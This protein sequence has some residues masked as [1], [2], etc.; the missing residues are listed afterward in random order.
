[1][2]YLDRYAR[3]WLE[4]R[5]RLESAERTIVVANLGSQAATGN[6]LALD[7]LARDVIEPIKRAMGASRYELHLYGGGRL[8]PEIS[9]ALDRPEVKNIGYIADIDSALLGAQVF[10]CLN[11][12][13]RYKVN[14]SRYLHAWSLGGCIV[15]HRDAALSLPEMV[16]G[17]NALLGESADEIAALVAQAAAH[18]PL[19]RRLGRNGYETYRRHFTA[20]SVAEDILGRMRAALGSD[21]RNVVLQS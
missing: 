10:L 17:E 13:T 6:M 5:E 16:H 18:K 12:A 3:A 15:A 21:D 2:I 7:Y 9:A 20:D 14:Q 8:R 19:R 11:N 4:E 1:M